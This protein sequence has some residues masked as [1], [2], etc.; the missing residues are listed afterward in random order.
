MENFEE[1]KKSAPQAHFDSET[2]AEEPFILMSRRPNAAAKL[3]KAPK[4]QQ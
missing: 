2:K 1:E 3:N 4:P